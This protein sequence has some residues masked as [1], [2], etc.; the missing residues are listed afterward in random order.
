MN[1]TVL[2]SYCMYVVS[3]YV[4][5]IDV[6]GVDYDFG[7]CNVSISK[8]KMSAK[9]CIDIKNDTELEENETLILTFS[10]NGI[11][12]DDIDIM[13]VDPSTAHI[14]IIDDECKNLI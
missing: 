4:Y 5:I 1:A 7:S 8:G 2:H 13:H 12:H 11:H 10:G 9:F 14:T 3:M 6:G